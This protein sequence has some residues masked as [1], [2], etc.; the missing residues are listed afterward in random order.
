MA[1][2][3][4]PLR[5]TETV[6][7]GDLRPHPRNYRGH[8][9]DQIEHLAA[10]IRQH[11][12]YRNIVIARDGTVLAGHGI[13]MAA[14]RLK[15]TEILATRMDLDPD[16]PEALK[17]LA[18]DNYLDHLAVDDD[19]ALT[20]LLRD[21]REKDG[22]LLGTGFDDGMLANLVMVT[23]SAEEINNIDTAAE[24]VGLPDFNH[25]PKDIRLM[26]RFDNVEDRDRLIEQLGLTRA[27]GLRAGERVAWS[28][29]WPPREDMDIG[30]VMWDA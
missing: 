6:K 9:D 3:K 22:D 18:A 19:R 7:L 29:W 30:S 26:V 4:P 14:E 16:D 5:D 10:S 28:A 13:V 11:G 20:E 24:W 2:R 17:I 8:P 12:F 15:M 1:K 27:G 23:R 21:V 25:D